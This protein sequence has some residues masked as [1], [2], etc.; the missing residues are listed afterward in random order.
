M[1]LA[2]LRELDSDTKFAIWKIEETAAELMDKLQLDEA[3]KNKLQQLSKGKRTLHWLATRVL[4]RYL[5][6]TDQYIHCPSD[7]NG[8]PYLPD[9]PY[10][11][12]LTHS[13][14]FAGVI[15]STKGPCG[16]DLEIVKEK[17]VRIKEKFLKPEELLFI[18]KEDEIAQLYAC[19]CAKEAVYKLQG[20]RGVSFLENMTIHPFTYRP[21]GVMTVDLFKDQRKF[22]FQVYYEKFQEYML[23]YVVEDSQ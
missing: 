10:E 15:L 13:F 4:L 12:S 5:L 20:N 19:W 2:Y 6:Q 7:A 11:L 23:G 17:V 18:R 22:S 14:D 16:I 8:K 3:E 1:A 9:Y 21:Q